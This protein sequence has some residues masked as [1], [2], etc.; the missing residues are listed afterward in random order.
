MRL[1]NKDSGFFGVASPH[2]ER[3]GNVSWVEVTR[4]KEFIE[5]IMLKARKFW[6]A[7][8][9]PKMLQSVEKL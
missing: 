4:D 5:D 1:A 8:V 6:E 9:F 2:L 3:D 7:A